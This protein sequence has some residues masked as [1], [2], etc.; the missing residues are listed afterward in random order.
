MRL[1]GSLAWRL[2]PRPPRARRRRPPVADGESKPLTKSQA[3]RQ[4]I[5]H[6]AAGLFRE[7][8]YAAGSLR[9]I[10]HAVGRKTGRL[11]YH[12]DSTEG[13]GGGVLPRGTQ[14][15]MAAS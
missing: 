13:L 6:A 10:A 4:A 14:G 12:F 15:R 5:L 11:S 1:T 2:R 3:T 9:D 8:G 7:K